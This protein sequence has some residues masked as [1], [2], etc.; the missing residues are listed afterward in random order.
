MLR[1]ENSNS[2][3][4]SH[5]PPLVATLILTHAGQQVFLLHYLIGC[6]PFKELN[7]TTLCPDLP[8]KYQDVALL[9]NEMKV[10]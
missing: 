6:D 5:N 2:D 10:V 9:S 7:Q 3:P 8:M 4:L 1:A